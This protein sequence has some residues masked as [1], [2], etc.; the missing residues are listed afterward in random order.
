MN[1]MQV[2]NFTEAIARA[3]A[4]TAEQHVLLGNGFSIACR[5]DCFRYS[6]LYRAA[7]F[8]GASADMHRIFEILETTDFERVIEAL[9]VATGLIEEY[10]NDATL[11]ARLNGDAEIV[12]DALARVLADR[13]REHSTPSR[14]WLSV[15]ED[16][17]RPRRSSSA[18]AQS[19]NRRSR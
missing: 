2:T 3:R 10:T 16:L 19:T 13:S 8:D 12:R 4:E 1:A 5:G 15:R 17:G 18:P 9:R 7:T 6:E 14:A 11:I